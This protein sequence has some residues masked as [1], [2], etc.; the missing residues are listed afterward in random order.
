MSALL[1]RPWVIL[2]AGRVGG[3]IGLLGRSLNVPI[4]ATWNRDEQGAEATAALLKPERALYGALSAHRALFERAPD[5]LIWLTVVDD[6]I[7]ETARA[8]A[9]WV[10]GDAIVVHTAGSLSSEALKQAGL[11]AQVA[12]LHPLQAIT[13]ARQG[14]EAM[15]Q[16][17]WTL[18]GEEQARVVLTKLMS[19][20]GIV[21]VEI[22]SGS[23]ILYHAAAVMAAN[24][25]VS[26]IE[27]SY[28]IASAA[29]LSASQ[30]Q[31][32]LIPLARSSLENLAERS[33]A[34]ALTG[35]VARGDART[36]ARHE[37]ALE[38]LED[39]EL[40]ELYR[41]LTRRAWRLFEEQDE[42]NWDEN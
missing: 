28:Q 25:L 14:F 18:E 2:G 39:P 9:P 41:A 21:P 1:S 31:A 27:A 19:Q 16:C 10:R 8:I 33:P 7:E 38:A 42:T 23:K 4:A 5:L 20:V 37:R 22:A 34:E 12:S 26:L 29:G 30:A 36:I 13:E 24:L 40:L 17:V 35:P 11:L 32:M 3:M 15:S 6:V